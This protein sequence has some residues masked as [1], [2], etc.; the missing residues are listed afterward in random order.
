MRLPGV[1]YPNGRK[2]FRSYGASGSLAD[3][4][5]RLAAIKDDNGSGSEGD[6]LASYA[7]N[8]AGTPVVEDFEQTDVKLDH[9]GGTSGTYAGF[10]RFGRVK[11]QLWRDYGAGADAEK[12]SYDYDCDSNRKYREDVAAGAASKKLDELYVYDDLNRLVDFKRGKLDANKTDIATTNGD[13]L[14]REEWSLTD[15]GNWSA[16]KIDANGDGDY[17]DA[18]DLDQTRTHNAVNEITDLSTT[19]SDPTYDPRG[20]L[21]ADQEFIRADPRPRPVLTR[22]DAQSRGG[23]T[24]CRRAVR[25]TT[26]SSTRGPQCGAH[27]RASCQF[28]APLDPCA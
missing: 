28:R 19:S 10:D 24:S 27:R 25:G 17:S 23:D 14:R 1:T 6:T 22:M 7:Y 9:F 12:L 4:L 18:G 11:Q 5:S 15:T 20:N 26:G 21:S 13:R 16:Y 3:K 2:S 8:G